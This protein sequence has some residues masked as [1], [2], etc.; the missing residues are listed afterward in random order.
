MHT[1]EPWQTEEDIRTDVCRA[2]G[3][4]LA[5]LAG[6]NVHNGQEEIVGCEG[7]LGDGEANAARIVSCVNALAGIQDPAAFVEAARGLV[8]A[9]DELLADTGVSDEPDILMTSARSYDA[10][11]TA[12]AA[13]LAQ[14]GD[15]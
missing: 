5:Y 6:W 14:M 9:A 15:E 7:I 13:F 10:L 3:D 11:Q 1:K 2:T 12:L 8:G 4:E